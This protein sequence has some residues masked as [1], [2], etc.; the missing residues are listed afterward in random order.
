MRLSR[1][2]RRRRIIVS[3]L[4]LVAL[5][6]VIG[7]RACFDREAWRA[8]Y[9]QLRAHL[10]ASYANLL[11]VRDVR[12]LD[13]VALDQRTQRALDDA[14]TDRQARRALEDFLAA[15][16]DGHLHVDRVKLSKRLERWW[17]ELG[18]DDAAPVPLDGETAPDVACAA[19]GFG[20]RDGDFDP[21]LREADGFTRL[22]TSD[23]V[24]ATAVLERPGA[25]WGLLRIGSFDPR[26]YAPACLRAWA[27]YRGALTGPCE[28]A[29]RDA[30]L[31]TAVPDQLLA[32]LAAAIE[33]LVAAGIDR[34]AVDVMGNGGGSD[35][36]D[37]A[38][39]MLSTKT[40]PCPRVAFLRHPHWS[41]R[42]R[43]RAAEVAEDLQKPQPD[44]DRALLERARARLTALADEAEVPCDLSRLWTDAA[45]PGCSNLV[46]GEYYA[47]GVY[48]WLAPGSLAGADARA[49]L[50][51]GLRYAYT[52]GRYDGPLVV[53][54]DGRTASAAEY[55]AAIL[56][57]GEAASI[58]GARTS[59][60]GCGYTG[61]G[62]P[63]V[64][65]RSGLRI[66]MP[67]CQ[68]LRRDGQNELAGVTP[69]HPA[70]WR[71][72][73]DASTRARALAATLDSL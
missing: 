17:A 30:F 26:A 37:P 54:V 46:A 23:S 12:G 29:C 21:A 70:P 49:L 71:D 68:R 73:D 35:W 4:A 72:G 62:V 7:E 52:P 11:W 64:L 45:A 43:A 28:E 61:G 58:V 9:L 2:G 16:A 53:L 56:R 38:A 31:Y 66:R 15:F 51:E 20:E 10:E 57:D 47:C 67:D 27:S 5:S 59:G 50:F 42:L 44:G 22:P 24:F 8:D 34:L 3:A 55:F 69:D 41:A 25:R 33:Q 40:L 18:R 36:V 32:E 13:L 39:R 14:A 19:L 60:A 65:E 48:E 6:W 1:R 63:V